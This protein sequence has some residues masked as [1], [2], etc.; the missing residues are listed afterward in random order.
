MRMKTRHAALTFA[1]LLAPALAAQGYSYDI[2]TTMTHTDRKTGRDTTLPMMMA[3]GQFEK[4]VSRLDVTHSMAPGGIMGTG[5]YII[6]NSTTRMTT[7]VDPAKKQYMEFDIA[8][9]SK[10]AGDLTKA[11]GGMMKIEITDVQVNLE[12]QGAGEKLEGYSTLKYKLTESYTMDMSIMGHSTKTPTHNTTEMWIAPDLDAIM[13]PTAR[14]D[15][16]K[17][18]AATGMMAPL[19]TAIMKAYANV[20]PGVPLKRVS[21]N[22]S[23]EGDKLRTTVTT[24]LI[25]NVKKGSI[26][27]S[28][29]EVPAGYTKVD[30]A[31]AA[32]GAAPAKP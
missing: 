15:L 10:E 2:S 21:T 31:A 12:S 23:G 19:T 3:H 25:T 7:F 4:G 1:M 5:T 6:S 13:N 8:E 24:M 18:A 20:K 29:F 28:V 22:V 30:F 17:A 16:A 27:A 26:P 14:P 11:L 32:A 9:L